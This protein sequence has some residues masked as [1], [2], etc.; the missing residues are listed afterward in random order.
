MPI[1]RNRKKTRTAIQQGDFFTAAHA[2]AELCKLQPND[3][4]VALL[5]ADVA[6]QCGVMNDEAADAYARTARLCV[7]HHDWTGGA[8]SMDHYYRLRPNGFMLGRELYHL[9]RA[10]Q[11][12]LAQATR[13]LHRDDAAAFAVREHPMLSGISDAAFDEL[14]SALQPQELLDGETVFQQGDL[15]D[16][17]YII[18]KGAVQP[19]VE[20]ED[21]TL[22][23]MQITEAGGISG[24]VP[25]LTGSKERTADVLAV[26]STLLYQLPY[27]ALQQVTDR[28]PE[29]LT[30]INDY[31][32]GHAAEQQL[33]Q[34]PFF[35]KLTLK[36]Q[37]DIAQQMERIT[38]AAGETLFSVG[39]RTNLDLYIVHAG[40]LSVNVAANGRQ[41]LLYT[42]KRGNVLGELGLR[43]NQRNVTVRAISEVQLFRWP[44]NLYRD[45]YLSHEWLRFK[46][47]DRLVDLNKKIHSL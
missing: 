22:Q 18:A 21:G 33:A 30:Y 39:D 45:Y 20:S 46:L 32:S 17:L 7:D 28:Y 34:T 3:L 41:H 2:L 9:A 37:R 27:Q 25:F 31:Y 19:W 29:V 5:Y 13:F 10:S 1:V 43:S 11:A 40:W 23:G 8:S 47:A 24:E 14:F 16:Y 6:E 44:E 42:A 15:A 35:H 36:E 38:V 26:G 12:T 4:E